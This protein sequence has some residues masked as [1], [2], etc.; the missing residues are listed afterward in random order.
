MDLSVR[1]AAPLGVHH[2]ARQT[3]HQDARGSDSRTKEA[4]GLS[5]ALNGKGCRRTCAKASPGW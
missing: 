5:Q 1:G 2:A 3:T 4:P